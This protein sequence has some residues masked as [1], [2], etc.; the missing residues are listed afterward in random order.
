VGPHLTTPD[1]NRHLRIDH[2]IATVG[3]RAVRGGVVVVVAQSLKIAAQFGAIVI[4]ARLLPP[5]A[6]GLIAMVAAVNAIFDLVKELG[7]SAAT[8]REN[9]ISHE[10]VTALFWINTGVGTAIAATLFAIAPILARFY[11]EPDLVGVT[12]VLALGFLMSGLSIQHC[13]LL[14]RQM[15]FLATA[16]LDTG[17]DLAGLAA[18]VAVALAG[19]GYWALVAQRLVGPILVLVGSWTLCPWRPARPGR[20]ADL[21]ELLG[22]GGAFTVSNVAVGF[23]RSIDQILIGWLWG[24]SSLGYYERASKLAMVPLNNINI[25]LYSV[26]MPALSRIVHESERYRQGFIAMIEKT[27][28]IVLPSGLLAA[29][30]ANVVVATLFGRGWGPAAPLVGFFALAAASLPLAMASYLLPATQNRPRDLMHATLIDSGLCLTL[31][32][33]GLPFG[34]GAVAAFYG[35][36]AFL[37]R[38]PIAF[39]LVT[40]RGAVSASDLWRAIGPSLFAG[41][42]VAVAVRLLEMVWSPNTITPAAHLAVLGIAGVVVALTAFAIVPRSR[43]SLIALLMPVMSFAG[44]RPEAMAEHPDGS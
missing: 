35:V 18:A 20:A 22:Y 36:G 40:R 14:R 34:V 39:W 28:M 15:R 31:I 3:R 25:P 32:M 4:L 8:I 24:P 2:L 27:A 44:A 9:D 26:A 43:R 30:C 1:Y 38:T 10:Q 42:S 41:A 17:G 6:F 33:A 13:A 11:E 7:L 23:S 37:V 16:S 21:R 5:R 12:R 19:G 29:S